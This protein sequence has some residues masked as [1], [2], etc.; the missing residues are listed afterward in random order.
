MAFG[1][2]ALLARRV[3]SAGN[4]F[5]TNT[6]RKEWAGGSEPLVGVEIPWKDIV[7]QVVDS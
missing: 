1:S 6:I 2:M 5:M 7:R 4:E 3:E